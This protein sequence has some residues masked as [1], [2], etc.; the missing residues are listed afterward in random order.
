MRFNLVN[1]W[2]CGQVYRL[3]IKALNTWDFLSFL[4]KLNGKPEFIDFRYRI[5]FYPIVRSMMDKNVV[6]LSRGSRLCFGALYGDSYRGRSWGQAQMMEADIVSCCQDSGSFLT[7]AGFGIRKQKVF[8]RRGHILGF[9]VSWIC[10]ETRFVHSRYRA[11]PNSDYFESYFSW[12]YWDEGQ[13]SC[14][15]RDVFGDKSAITMVPILQLGQDHTCR[16]A[17]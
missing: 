4:R 15:R 17:T 12:R 2:C 13:G 16:E 3:L 5:T 9:F 8:F 6:E 11:S 1:G 10:L 14:S 7:W